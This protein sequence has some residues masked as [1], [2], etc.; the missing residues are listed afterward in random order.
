MLDL[1]PW[2]AQLRVKP[3]PQAAQRPQRRG[4]VAWVSHGDG[5]WLG[6]FRACDV[7]GPRAWSQEMV[8]GAWFAGDIAFGGV[9]ARP[10]CTELAYLYPWQVKGMDAERESASADRRE[11]A[12]QAGLG[13]PLL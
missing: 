1:Y 2:S 8:D 13:K 6:D 12:Q 10:G 3:S 4:I 11:R 7:R 5:K 9:I